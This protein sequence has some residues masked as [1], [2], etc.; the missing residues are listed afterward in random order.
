MPRFIQAAHKS[1]IADH[2]CKG[3]ELEGRRIAIFNLGGKFFA[4]DDACSHEGGSLS[5]GYI[6]GEEVE[7]PWHAAHFNIKTGKVCC[8]P[9]ADDLAVY[10]VR[11]VGD[12]IEVEV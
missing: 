6:E 7:C 8:P 10:K 12:H 1:E 11:I 4:V 2:S 3:V 9:A 5:E